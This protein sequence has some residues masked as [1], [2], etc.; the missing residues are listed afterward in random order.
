MADQP[1][2][3]PSRTTT[4]VGRV[5]STSNSTRSACSRTERTDP[6]APSTSA[7]A[8]SIHARS[9]EDTASG[10]AAPTDRTLAATKRNG[11]GSGTRYTNTWRGERRGGLRSPTSV[12]RAE[13]IGSSE[14]M[15]LT[16]AARSRQ[17]AAS[18][19]EQLRIA[20]RR[21][22]GTSEVRSSLWADR[23]WTVRLTWGV[24]VSDQ[25]DRVR[26][27]WSSGRLRRASQ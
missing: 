19:S 14:R 12:N 26:T 23:M 4:A 8:P 3:Q 22:R 15:W 2:A 9:G 6:E 5:A 11:T 18:R 13:S 20:G 21:E 7:G 27:S 24:S 1:R 10:G 17:E 25:A 16:P